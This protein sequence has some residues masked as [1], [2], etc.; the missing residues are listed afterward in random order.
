MNNVLMVGLSVLATAILSAPVPA[1]D[2]SGVTAVLCSSSWAAV[3]TSI[4]KF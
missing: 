2:L 3:C 4:V 1:D